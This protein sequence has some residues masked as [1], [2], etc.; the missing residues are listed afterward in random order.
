MDPFDSAAVIGT[1]FR[2][3]G[4]EMLT[5]IRLTYAVGKDKVN[6]GE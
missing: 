5:V 1:R 3:E 2:E 6:R 4:D